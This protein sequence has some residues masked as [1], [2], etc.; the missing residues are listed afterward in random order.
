MPDSY[1]VK[2]SV[3]KI[4][5]TNARVI[6]LK[7]LQHSVSQST[8]TIS[9]DAEKWI[10]GSLTQLSMKSILLINIK[11]P[12]VVAILTINSR[13]VCAFKAKKIFFSILVSISS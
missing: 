6:S 12:T 1:F 7:A 4:K 8:N 11:M 2:H 9:N 3:T 10:D 5:V 13:I